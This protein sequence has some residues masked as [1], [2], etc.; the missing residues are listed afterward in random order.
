MTPEFVARLLETPLRDRVTKLC[1]GGG[2]HEHELLPETCLQLMRGFPNLREFVAPSMRTL[3][4]T[5][6]RTEFFE[7]L[8][9]AAPMLRVLFATDVDDECMRIICNRW[10]LEEITF[11]IYRISEP[12]LCVTP[13]VVDIIVK[14]SSA[15]SISKALISSLEKDWGAAE[16]LGIVQGCP[17]LTDVL[18][19]NHGELESGSVCSA[20]VVSTRRL[21]KSRGG[22][23]LGSHASK[24]PPFF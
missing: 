2:S 14:S 6:S 24:F 15:R 23:L 20:S 7:Q 9:L 16:L 22:T 13:A 17:N 19:H 21:L 5:M 18:Y 3:S 4:Q 10:Q 1:F 11:F 12:P 8:A